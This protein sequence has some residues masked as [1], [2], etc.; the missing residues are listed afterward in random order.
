MEKL[1]GIQLQTMWRGM[2]IEHR[3]AIVKAIARYQA[4]WS[5]F[6]FRHYG[7]LYYSEDLRQL[8]QRFPIVKGPGATVIDPKFMIGPSTA[9][10][11]N[12][13]G[14]STVEFDRGPCKVYG[15]H[16]CL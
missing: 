1:P 15:G 2:G 5:S 9:R 10:V 8:K 13:D 3:L 11:F 16:L 4:T 12:D 7:S 14:R 6:S